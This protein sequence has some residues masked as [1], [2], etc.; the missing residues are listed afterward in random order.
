M[1]VGANQQ[2]VKTEE[3]VVREAAVLAD[4]ETAHAQLIDARARERIR[5]E[6]GNQAEKINW[7]PRKKARSKFSKEKQPMVNRAI[8]II[9][10]NREYWPLTVRQVHYRMLNSPVMRN[11]REKTFYLND[12]DCYEDLTD[13][14]ARARIFGMVPWGAITDET[15]PYI[16][17][18]LWDSLGP[19]LRAAS[20][21]MFAGYSR[22]LLQTQP[23]FVVMVA[24]KLTVRGILAPICAR[25]TMPLLVG[26][27]YSDVGS[28]RNIAIAFERSGKERLVILFVTDCDPEGENIPNTIISNLV[29]D[30][31]LPKSKL[32]VR[33]VAITKSQATS[34]GLTP[35]MAKEQSS[36]KDGYLEKHGTSNVWELEALTPA[37]LRQLTIEAIESSI[38]VNAF[39]A[40]VDREKADSTLLLAKAMKIKRFLS[41]PD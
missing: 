25:F 30:L 5:R 26:R 6:T 41:L 12:K 40:E 16:L 38:D 11:T 2:R 33:K 19:Y 17:E 37:Q 23:D 22:N 29:M 39:N 4:P 20:E 1:L 24:E 35:Q 28:I 10:E 15:R 32:D 36:R 34:L 18:T 21:Q 8:E 27:G 13:V 7:I 14:L 31:G 9:E 3:V